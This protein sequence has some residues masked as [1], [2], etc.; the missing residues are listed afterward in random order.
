MPRNLLDLARLAR[1]YDREAHAPLLGL[2]RQRALLAPLVALARRRDRGAGRGSGG[3]LERGMS[4]LRAVS[5]LGATITMGLVAG[6]LRPL[7]AHDH[8]RAAAADDRTFVTAFQAIDRAILNPWFM[9]RRSSARSCSRVA[10]AVPTSA[11]AAR[12]GSWRR[13]ACYLIAACVMTVAVNVPLNDAIK[14]AGRPG[15]DPRP[16]RR[17]QHFHEARWAAW[18]LVRAVTSTSAFA[19]LAWALVLYGRGTA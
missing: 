12:R 7:R 3:G 1:R 11:A 2:R 5:L 10:A 15:P 8:A 6:V 17:A 9:V 4:A 18:N 16:R 14:A 19:C 13:S